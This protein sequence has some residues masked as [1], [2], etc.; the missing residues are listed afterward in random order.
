[1][2]LAY[3]GKH[4]SLAQLRVSCGVSRDGSKASHLVKAA[5]TF[6]FD[7]AGKQ[8]SVAALAVLPPPSILFWEFNHYVVWEGMGRRRGKPVVYINDPAQGRRTLTQEE[9]SN[10]FTGIALTLTPNRHFKPGGRPAGI[11][12]DLPGRLRGTYS[13]LAIAA[14]AGLLLV[15]VTTITP[16]FTR[17]FIDTVIMGGSNP[18]LLAFF[19]MMAAVVLTTAYLIHTQQT[20]LLHAE[21][22]SSTLSSARF[23][24]HLLRLPVAFFGQR[25]PADIAERL[26]KNDSVA[27][28]LS[29]NV[30]SAVSSAAVA[31]LFAC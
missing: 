9:F 19:S 30:T 6:G 10:S 28:V 3:Y 17:G 26:G 11:M 24:R 29:R 1:M 5:R 25:S 15:G 18:P 16:A 23:L 7:A 13:A 2:I 21:M 4:L 27:E 14:V 20:F 22:S 8:V 31:V 12:R